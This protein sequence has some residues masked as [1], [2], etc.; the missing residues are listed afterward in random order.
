[1]NEKCFYRVETDS[2]CDGYATLRGSGQNVVAYSFYG[3]SSNSRVSSHY[4]NQ[5]AQRAQEI[6]QF[7]PKWIMR[8]YYY[9]QDEKSEEILCENWCQNPHLDL[10]DVTNLPILGDLKTLQPIGKVF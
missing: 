3:N 6:K 8:I 7:Y 2:I 5:I 10:C 9:I 4:L 1:M